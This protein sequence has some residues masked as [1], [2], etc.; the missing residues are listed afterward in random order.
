MINRVRNTV[1]SILNKDN[2]GYITPEEFNL[3]SAQA[4]I[5]VFEQKFFDYSIALNKQNAGLHGSDFSN[6]AFKVEQTIDRF[7]TPTVLV[8]NGST[9]K[10]YAP[11][12]DPSSNDSKAYRIE[13]LYYNNTVEIERVSE[14]KIRTL[15]NTPMTSPS[16]LYPVYTLDEQGLKVYPTS[17]VANVNV[18]YIRYPKDP[19][20]T[21]T[22]LSGGE[23]LFDQGATD[24]QDF[25]LPADDEVNLILKIL[26][27][28]GVQIR[29]QE[30]YQ[31]AKSD[32]V[33]NNQDK[34]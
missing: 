15:I 18:N 33:Q 17:I 31:A 21:Y 14:G 2:R 16:V 30:V 26:E 1:L 22:S 4:Q 3:Y 27:Y 28:S 10:F 13:K 8:Y 11:G 29:E 32:E 24:Y 9:T 20:W 7:L 6:I 12:E 23:P 34:V 25:E 19:K 5:E